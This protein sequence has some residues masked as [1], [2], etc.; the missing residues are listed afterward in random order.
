VQ[1]PGT[2]G[3]IG[4]SRLLALIKTPEGDVVKLDVL[5]DC[6]K[7]L[8][9]YA[10]MPRDYESGTKPVEDTFAKVKGIGKVDVALSIIKRMLPKNLILPIFTGPLRGSLWFIA[11]GNAHYWIGDYEREQVILFARSLKSDTIFYDIGA[12]AGYYSILASKKVGDDGEVYSF[13]PLPRNVSYLK[14]NVQINKCKNVNIVES[15]ISDSDGMAL[16]SEGASSYE[17]K[18]SPYGEINVSMKS[19]DSLMRIS[20]LKKPDMLKIDV[21]GSEFRVLMGAKN[22]ITKFKPKIFLSIH[23]PDLEKLCLNFLLSINYRILKIS[24]DK[25]HVYQILAY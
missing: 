16:F 12:H 2:I 7:A 11:S 5:K 4:L 10:I 22:T 9:A 13:E 3:G 23:S 1:V 14:K 25:D 8:K 19:I 21:Q 18:I 20:N 24:Y 6:L 17:G 15:A